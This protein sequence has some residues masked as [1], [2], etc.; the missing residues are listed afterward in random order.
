[1]RIPLFPTK[2]TSATVTG[3]PVPQP[4]FLAQ[5]WSAFGLLRKWAY[6]KR[7]P[8]AND[9]KIMNA[10]LMLVALRIALPAA[11]GAV[12]ILKTSRALLSLRYLLKKPALAHVE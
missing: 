11:A 2:P 5:A 1:M 10:K 3:I 6:R 7:I 9:L 12:P 8:H 4:A